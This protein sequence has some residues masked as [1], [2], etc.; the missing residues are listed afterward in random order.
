MPH[1]GCIVE[2]LGRVDEHVGF[3]PGAPRNGFREIAVRVRFSRR[4]RQH[5]QGI[6]VHHDC[7]TAGSS[8][9]A[10]ELVALKQAHSNVVVRHLNLDPFAGLDFSILFPNEGICGTKKYVESHVRH[11]LHPR[12]ELIYRLLLHCLP[13]GNPR[14]GWIKEDIGEVLPE[15]AVSDAPDGVKPGEL[16]R[17]LTHAIATHRVFERD[18]CN[19]S[20]IVVDVLHLQV[21]AF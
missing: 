9:L 3:H 1:G 17:F 21:F 14:V 20:H 6:Q 5:C 19:V 18:R 10:V 11:C 7:Q 13:T 16:K 4:S 12:S 8:H 15:P 2:S